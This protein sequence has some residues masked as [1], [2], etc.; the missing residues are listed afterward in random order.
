MADGEV[1]HWGLLAALAALDTAAGA[2]A[3]VSGTAGV[4]RPPA[5]GDEELLHAAT[6][7]AVTPRSATAASLCRYMKCPFRSVL[8]QVQLTV[9]VDGAV[10]LAVKPMVTEL[11]GAMVPL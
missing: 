7:H 8:G 1:E 3:G 4:V 6:A 5:D 11:P 9:R 10:P 2:P